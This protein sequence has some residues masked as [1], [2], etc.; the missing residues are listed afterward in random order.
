[1][2]EAYY[3]ALTL[4][5]PAI[6]NDELLRYR[7]TIDAETLKDLL[8]PH[9]TSE[10]KELD[11]RCVYQQAHIQRITGWQVLWGTPKTNEYAIEAGSVFL[12]KCPTSQKDTIL[13]ALYNLEQQ[14]IGKRLLEGF[15]RVRISDEFHQEV[16]WL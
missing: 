10:L 13:E 15:G 5:A 14:G 7:G 12:F 4:H 9:T 3:F 16:N 8:T 2:R 11:L 6:L 1:M